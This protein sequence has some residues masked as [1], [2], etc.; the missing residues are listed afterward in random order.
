MFFLSYFESRWLRWWIVG[1]RVT[2]NFAPALSCPI[3]NS[4]SLA[5]IVSFNFAILCSFSHFSLTSIFL[6]I[7]WLI[8]YFSFVILHFGLNEVGV[9]NFMQIMAASTFNKGK[10]VFAISACH[11]FHEL[12]RTLSIYTIFFAYISIEKAL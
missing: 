11:K 7:C 5:D 10:T 9:K 1:C 2:V 12:R 4:L 3:P 8:S 6:F